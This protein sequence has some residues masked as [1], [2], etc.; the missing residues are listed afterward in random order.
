INMSFETNP[1]I[2]TFS[3][4][5]YRDG[6]LEDYITIAT[7]LEITKNAGTN[8]FL[9]DIR[10]SQ[11]ANETNY[12]IIRITDMAGVV[13]EG[14]G[15]DPR[16]YFGGIDYDGADLYP[17]YFYRVDG[18]VSNTPLNEY[19]PYMLDYLPYGGTIARYA[20]DTVNLEW[21]WTD[22]V[23]A[24]ATS[25]EQSVLLADFT[26]DPE[27][28]LEPSEENEL[29]ILY[30]VTSE[31]GDTYTYYYITVTDVTYN[32]TLVFDVY[33]CT[34]V[35]QGTCTLASQ[36]IDF[37]NELVIISVKN[38]DTDGDDTAINKI[39]PLDY[40]VFTVIQ[41]LNNQVTQFQYTY[42]GDYRYSFGRNISGFYVFSV[43]LPLDQ[44]LNDLYDYEIEFS[45][46]T[47][48]YLLFDASDYVEGLEGKYFYIEPST[49][50]R[51]RRFNIYIRSVAEPATDAPWGLFDF[52]R[53]W[54]D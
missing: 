30:R 34:G 44:Y 37:D 6:S 21:Y 50:N 48:D 35:D 4:V 5:Y 20:Y 46:T 19:M 11:L 24:G 17:Y 40:P 45:Y 42:D 31:D 29:L 36:S 33:Y 8:P 22:E 28:G 51:T 23:A 53:S 49:R 25:E 43:E 54:W 52:F 18:Q 26:I 39:D 27:T 32:V 3:F 9:S 14:T 15:Y 1:G 41:A 12:P 7:S 38:F 13:Q 10:F 2:Y 47:A 16:V